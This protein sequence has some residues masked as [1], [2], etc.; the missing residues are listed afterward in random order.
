MRLRGHGLAWSAGG[1]R[2]VDGVDI[3]CAP[4]TFTGLLGPNGS[5]KTS[6]LRLLTGTQVPDEGTVTLDGRGMHELRRRERARHLAVVE[7]H[8]DTGLDLTVRQVVEL[9]RIPHRGRWPSARPGTDAALTRAMRVG[10]V[11]ALADRRWSTL[12]GGER[13]RVQLARALAQEPSVLVLDEPTNHLDLGHQIGFMELVRGL[14]ITAVAALHDLDLAA[15]FCDQVVVME[16]GR[17]VAGGDPHT[18]LTPALLASVY[19]VRAAVD[20]HAVAD[21]LRVTWI[22]T[23]A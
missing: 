8:A 13:Q 20:R 3:E 11:E 6:L 16:R 4:G 22:G 9:G 21:R 17:V 7:Q 1:R 5:G 14:G 18:V 15:A 12:S 2:I 19:G 23:Q 10:E